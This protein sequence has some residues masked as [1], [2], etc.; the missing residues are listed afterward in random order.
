MLE[1]LKCFQLQTLRPMLK[2][3]KQGMSKFLQHLE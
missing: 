3:G 2:H 1:L